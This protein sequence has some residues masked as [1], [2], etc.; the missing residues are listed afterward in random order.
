M[1]EHFR[2]FEVLEGVRDD[3][4]IQLLGMMGVVASLVFVGLQMRQSQEIALA[5]QQTDRMQ[6]FTDIVNAFTEAGIQ[7]GQ[8]FDDGTD[9]EFT[10]T[11]N[12][13][14]NVAH[15]ALW[16]FENDYLQ[17]SLGLMDEN[18]WEAKLKF[19]LASFSSCIGRQVFNQ[20]RESL[21]QRIVELIISVPAAN[22]E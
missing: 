20:R 18:I 14:I 8:N 10:E 19:M 12:P 16:V 17:Y 15:Q 3:V 21:D 7:Y 5:A 1:F 13:G 11:F 22:C 6:V 4:W 2:G 9:P